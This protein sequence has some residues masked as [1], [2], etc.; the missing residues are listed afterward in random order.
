MHVRLGVQLGIETSRSK[1][2]GI[3]FQ[4]FGV[5]IVRNHLQHEINLKKKEHTAVN[6]LFGRRPA[7]QK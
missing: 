6:L 1:M 5:F 7:C 4:A 3:H 2:A